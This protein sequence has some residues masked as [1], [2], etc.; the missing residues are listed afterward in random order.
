MRHIATIT[1]NAAE[2][3]HVDLHEWK[4]DVYCDI[5]VWYKAEPGAD[6]GVHPTTKG[7]RFNAELLPDL[8][9]AIDAAIQAIEDG[10]KIGSTQETRHGG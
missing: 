3:I 8:R 6:G 4:S 9:S 2:E 10:E 5:R 7:L 1:K